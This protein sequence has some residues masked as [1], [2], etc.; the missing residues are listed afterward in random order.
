MRSQV[1]N[2]TH[3]GGAR[4]R[5]ISAAT[6]PCCAW[7]LA[8]VFLAGCSNES[9]ATGSSS[10]P[11]SR[12]SE[13]KF[14]PDRRETHR[15]N[16]GVVDSYGQPVGRGV[17][18]YIE[19]RRANWRVLDEMRL[20]DDPV[21]LAKAHGTRME[22]DG[23]LRVNGADEVRAIAIEC[24]GEIGFQMDV[25]T[26]P[27][28][29]ARVVAEVEVTAWGWEPDAIP[30]RVQLFDAEGEPV[31]SAVAVTPGV[32]TP[33][34]LHDPRRMPV[35]CRTCWPWE[36]TSAKFMSMPGSV[37]RASMRLDGGFSGGG[38]VTIELSNET[39]P[40][41][42]ADRSA[43][44]LTPHD[45]NEAV[46]DGFANRVEQI[47]IN[48]LSDRFSDGPW[49]VEA[50]WR[51]TGGGVG[52]TSNR[53]RKWTWGFVR[54]SAVKLC[55]LERSDDFRCKVIRCHRGHDS[56]ALVDYREPKEWK[57]VVLK[58]QFRSFESIVLRMMGAGGGPARCGRVQLG[59]DH[60]REEHT[61]SFDTDSDGW[62]SI[63]LDYFKPDQSG[64]M[65]DLFINVKDC[66]GNYVMRIA[67]SHLRR[68]PDQTY[69]E[70]AEQVAEVLI[71][72]KEFIGTGTFALPN[73]DPLTGYVMLTESD[74]KHWAGPFDMRQSLCEGR[75]RYRYRIAT[76]GEV[77]WGLTVDALLTLPGASQNIDPS[78][79]RS[80]ITVDIM[81]ERHT[82][83]TFDLQARPRD[84]SGGKRNEGK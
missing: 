75:F 15:K 42:E 12:V 38:K 53:G 29:L 31:G 79:A 35:E 84:S 82:V 69:P 20:T 1:M 64:S 55:R 14:G 27:I 81:H 68:R 3:D 32:V 30:L 63:P 18:W 74:A 7:V 37:P 76:Q 67:R 49:K 73:G 16:W 8:I 40:L 66:S 80:K 54:G 83:T 17:A 43:V 22:F 44:I 57:P 23:T 13:L 77:P 10:A 60:Q 71:G 52:A 51:I 24:G 28:R 36:R 9:E 34:R 61:K 5:L 58:A 50:D 39:G 26:T 47:N 19:N 6:V 78:E 72:G 70:I 11:E 56:I 4:R 48:D 41:K 62:V 65:S 33:I 25:W 45:L 46:V 21:P 2:G 59:Y